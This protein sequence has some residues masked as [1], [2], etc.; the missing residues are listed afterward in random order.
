MNLEN[1]L[2]NLENRKKGTLRYKILLFTH[3][4]FCPALFINFYNYELNAEPVPQG[5][6]NPDLD[7]LKFLKKI[8]VNLSRYRR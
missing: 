7:E 6:I 1:Q 3:Y 8:L 4:P 5:G 2:T